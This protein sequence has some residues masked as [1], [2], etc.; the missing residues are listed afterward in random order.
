MGSKAPSRANSKL[1]FGRVFQ[2]VAL[3]SLRI[4]DV[5]GSFF[6]WL[7]T[8]PLGEAITEG[9]DVI[10]GLS[11]ACLQGFWLPKQ[12]MMKPKLYH[13]TLSL[14]PCLSRPM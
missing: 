14:C 3:Q 1:I 2:T 8:H 5:N 11:L 7:Q 9:F 10:N 12:S 6:L 13:P 4:T